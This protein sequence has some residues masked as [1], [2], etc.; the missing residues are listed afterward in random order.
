[1]RSR[2]SH[3]QLVHLLRCWR[4]AESDGG[5]LYAFTEPVPGQHWV[6]NSAESWWSVI[7]TYRDATG[8]AGSSFC[9]DCYSET[10]FCNNHCGSNPPNDDMTA[11]GFSIGTA[12]ARLI[13]CW[14]AHAEAGPVPIPDGFTARASIQNCIGDPC[15]AGSQYVAIGDRVISGTTVTSVDAEPTNEDYGRAICG[16]IAIQ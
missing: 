15:A 3:A 11:L 14:S 6:T 10:T 16:M 13:G 7:L 5:T 12:G 4:F 9:T 1:M 8:I 2:R